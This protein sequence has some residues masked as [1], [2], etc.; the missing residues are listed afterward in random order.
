MSE[1]TSLSKA[2][3]KKRKRL[4]KERKIEVQLTVTFFRI[5]SFKAKKTNKNCTVTLIFSN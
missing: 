2:R 4:K 1:K 3:S 5:M